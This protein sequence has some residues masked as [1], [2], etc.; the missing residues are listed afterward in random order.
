MIV[1][2]LGVF[3]LGKITTGFPLETNILKLLPETRTDP[4]T[5]RAYR[6]FEEATGRKTVFMVGSESIEEAKL[7]AELLH[8]AMLDSSLFTEISFRIDPQRTEKTYQ[9]YSPYRHS[10][11][12]REQRLALEEENPARITAQALKSLMSPISVGSAS[13][14][15]DP[16]FTFLEFLKGLQSQ[17]GAFTVDGDVLLAE[18]EDRHYVILV[19]ELQDNAFSLGAQAAFKSFFSEARLALTNQ[20]PELQVLSAGVIH[21]AIAGTDSARQDIS[22]IGLG[23][24]F[25]LLLLIVLAFRS[26]S[27]LLVSAIPILTGCLTALSVCLL[28]FGQVHLFTLV[29]GSSLIGVSIDYSFHYLA[30]RQGAGANWNSQQGLEHILPGISLGLLTSLAAYIALGVA[31]FSGLREIALFSA[32]GLA[33]AYFTVVLWYPVFLKNNGTEHRALSYRFSEV[34]VGFWEGQKSTVWLLILGVLCAIMS[35]YLGRQLR[36]NDDIRTL[37]SSPPGIIAEE[38]LV[39]SIVGTSSGSQFFVVRGESENIVLTAEEELTELLDEQVKLGH[40]GRYRA[41]TKVLPSATRQAHNYSMLRRQVLDRDSVFSKYFGDMEFEDEVTTNFRKAFES[42]SNPTLKVDEWLKSPLRDLYAPLWMSGEDRGEF[43]SILILDEVKDLE[44]MDRLAEGLPTVQFVSRADDISELLAD[45]RNMSS[46]LV[47][48]A[49]A[50]IFVLLLFRYHW[51][52]ACRV[53]FPPI[54]AGLAAMT[55]SVALGATVNLFNTL[56]LVLV[57]G[58]GIDYTIFFAEKSSQRATTMHAIFL[59]AVTTILSFGLLALSGTPVI[60]SFGL[61]VF[62]GIAVSLLLC[63]LVGADR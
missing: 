35:F 7:G 44:A 31:P 57:L 10:L 16:L 55:V 47:A 33:G 50:L 13:L 60:S 14:S 32:A 22:T 6:Q 30:E 53:I 39:K 24:V 18:H 21:H 45:Y 2:C 12:S 49:Y 63:P 27:P 1:V 26:L 9:T 48:G 4:L 15:E 42:E 23:S 11:L 51:K 29:F 54:A 62:V 52:V 17:A 5:E 38:N 19:G 3:L 43:A 36:T 28:V 56:A 46:W 8:R 61:V 34:Y 58:I 20:N 41:I 37:Q 40:L 59:S 25:G